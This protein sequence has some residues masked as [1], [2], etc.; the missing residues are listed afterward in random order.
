MVFLLPIVLYPLLGVAALVMAKLQAEQTVT[1]G[2]VGEAYLPPAPPL[3]QDGKFADDL[4]KPDATE[5][6]SFDDADANLGPLRVVSVVAADAADALKDKKVDVVL[7]VPVNFAAEA[8]G[9]RKPVLTVK[10]RDGDE[11]SKLAARRVKGIVV[12]W[13]E[14]LREARFV[15]AGLPKDF[16]EVFQIADPNT[17]KEKTELAAL[18][19]RDLLSRAL[20]FLLMM[21]LL[22]GAIQPAVDLTAGEKERGTME[23]LLISPADRS[24]IVL[25]KFLAVTVYSF[26]S[27]LW[28]VVWLSVGCAIAAAVLGHDIVN[29]YGL[30]G[31]V[32]VGIPMAMLF[33]AVCIA[34]GVF[35]RSTK[36]GQYYLVPLVVVAMPL[37]FWSLMPGKELDLGSAFIP[38]A[39]AMLLQ[40]KLLSVSADP[41]PWTM[42][43][44]VLGGL[45]VCV[46]VALY[47]AVRQFK[48]EDV[49]FR[50]LGGDK[51]GLSRLF[52]S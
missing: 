25:G 52:G 17:G 31:C 21:W 43:A 12:R 6:T 41:T 19:L 37:A 35:A 46:T 36:E 11:K 38:V 9:R 34:L 13:R 28:N 29:M 42:F 1:V 24:E 16:H 50:E 33:S 14:K 4:L 44:P 45:T 23:T 30:I 26:A 40:Q 18:E 2:V 49:L 47:A 8:D 15:K 10:R 39:G 22:A 7:E 20:P 48:R 5:P 27:V 3:V 32:V 51:G